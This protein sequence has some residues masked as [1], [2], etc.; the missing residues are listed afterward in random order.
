MWPRQG[1]LAT[2]AT[3][4]GRKDPPWALQGERSPAPPGSLTSGLQNVGEQFPAVFHTPACGHLSRPPQHIRKL[5]KTLQNQVGS[6]HRP[7][8]APRS[9]SWARAGA[10]TSRSCGEPR[11]AFCGSPGHSAWLCPKDSQI[12]GGKPELG[13]DSHGLPLRTTTLSLVLGAVTGAWWAPLGWFVGQISPWMKEVMPDP[14]PTA[15]G[16]Y[17]GDPP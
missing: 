1:P 17:P 3:G 10:R 14:G 16:C 13:T 7:P 12:W 15:H 9:L 11:E 5:W 6:L 8:A 2:P 4:R